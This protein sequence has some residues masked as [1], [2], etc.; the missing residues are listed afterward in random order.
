LSKLLDK[1]P[2]HRKG[3]I[4]I[5]LAALMWSSGGLFIKIL[6]RLELNA[7]QICFFRSFIA[8]FTILTVSM[9][10]NKKI[11]FEF[12]IVS[13]LCSAAFAGILIFFVV[14]T[15]LTTVANVIFL[16]FTAPVYLLFLE[17]IF[18]KTK[19]KVKNIVTVLICL[20]GMALF[21]FGKIEVGNIYG[22]MIAI[23]SGVSFA[24][25]SLFLKW[26]KQLHKSENTLSQIALGNFFVA[27]ICFPIVFNK[28][29]ISSQE[30]LILGFLGIFQIGIS[31]VIY[32]EGIKYVSAVE[33]LIIAMLEAIFNPFWVYLGI[34]EKPS[35]FALLG[36][37]VILL[38]ILANNFYYK[39][40]SDDKLFTE[41]G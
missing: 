28:L 38:G 5:S 26:K 30:L 3:L 24:L 10:R 2:F 13:L 11:K 7:F 1:I 29:I 21:F 15:T 12:D 36:G 41:T 37:F 34:G 14:A 18:L 17:P 4:Y 40:N 23:L 35:N 9:F 25:F 33:S 6:S 39:G 27:I 32:N 22:N 8:G 31:Y 19:F 20:S 16:Q